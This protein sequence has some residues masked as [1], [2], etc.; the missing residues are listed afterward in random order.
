MKKDLRVANDLITIPP[1]KTVR[2][3][4]IF[5]GFF[6]ALA[7]IWGFLFLEDVW[8]SRQKGKENPVG[9]KYSVKG[10]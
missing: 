9:G 8:L 2:N 10:N 1:D 5:C 7:G 4:N 6:N 3:S